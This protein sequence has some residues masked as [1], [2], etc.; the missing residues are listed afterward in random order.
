MPDNTMTDDVSIVTEQT[1]DTTREETLEAL[2]KMACSELDKIILQG[3]AI[4]SYESSAST[5][6]DK[7]RIDRSYFDMIA[8]WYGAQAWWAKLAL[9]IAVAVIAAGIGFFIGLLIPLPV[10]ALTLYSVGLLF[11]ENHYQVFNDREVTLSEDVKALEASLAESVECLSDIEQQM[12]STFTAL[13]DLH[14]QQINYTVDFKD[15]VDALEAQVQSLEVVIEAMKTAKSSLDESRECIAESARGFAEVHQTLSNEATTL[16][17]GHL[18]FS[19]TVTS[20][21]TKSDALETIQEKFKQDGKELTSLVQQTKAFVVE[22]RALDTFEHA[23]QARASDTEALLK[24]AREVRSTAMTRGENT[25][26][27][28]E[29]RMH[30]MQ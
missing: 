25:R 11:L 22:L 16:K 19:S 12:K 20:L 23:A 30:V 24:R 28:S 21:S 3:R 8:L 15:Q 10:V 2:Q 14:L 13:F 9:V 17:E 4:K 27:S 26:P 29:N 18:A 5:L 1:T 6:I 7:Q